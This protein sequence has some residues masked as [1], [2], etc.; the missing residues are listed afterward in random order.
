V[1]VHARVA[2][3]LVLDLAGRY[4]VKQLDR[5]REEVLRLELDGLH[6]F[7]QV[8]H[9]LHEPAGVLLLLPFG[10]AQN[11]DGLLAPVESPRHSPSGTSPSLTSVFGS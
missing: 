8:G 7:A 6:P 4:L 3:L 1:E 5:A 9:V 10:R 2:V 11:P